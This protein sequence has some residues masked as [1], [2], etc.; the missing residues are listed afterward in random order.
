MKIAVIG[1]GLAG[2]QHIDTILNNKNCELDLIVDPSQ[3]A[4][5]LSKKLNVQ[6]FSS[7]ELALEKCRPDGAIIATPNSR[8]IE[9]AELFLNEK[10]PVLIEKPLSSDIKSAI[11]IVMYAK[12]RKLKF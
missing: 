8:H 1:A 7:I 6:Y 4:C 12:N 3:E 10:I 2:K 9:N 5:E 11:E